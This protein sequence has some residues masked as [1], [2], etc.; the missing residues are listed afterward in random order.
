MVTWL[1][2]SFSNFKL[3][4]I[5][6]ANEYI[7]KLNEGYCPKIPT[8]APAALRQLLKRCFM[9]VNERATAAQ[10]LKDIHNMVRN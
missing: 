10:L 8:A 2:F 6:R 1:P 3:I 5:S 4:F 9:R 7:L